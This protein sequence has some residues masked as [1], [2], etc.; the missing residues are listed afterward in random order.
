MLLDIIYFSFSKFPPVKTGGIY[1]NRLCLSAKG[2]CFHPPVKTGG[3]KIGI[4]NTTDNQKYIGSFINRIFA[5]NNSIGFI[6]S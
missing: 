5:F 3:I 4:I 2:G 6:P 1:R